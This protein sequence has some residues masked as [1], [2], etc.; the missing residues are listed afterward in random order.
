MHSDKGQ[1]LVIIEIHAKDGR[2]LEARERLLHAIRTSAKPG[3]ISSQEYEDIN[4]R[5][6]FYATQLWESVDDFDVHMKH[7][8]DSG[9]SEEIQVLSQNPTTTVLKAIS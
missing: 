8:A 3:M 1:V 9:M 2:D 7:A 6:A 4:E 5:G